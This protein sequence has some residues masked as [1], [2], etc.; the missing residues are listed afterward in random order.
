V[1]RSL[2]RS[3]RFRITAAATLIVTLATV[4]G[5][6]VFITVLRGSLLDGVASAAQTDAT[7]IGDRLEEAGIASV[8]DDEDVDDRFFQVV[9][10]DGALLVSSENAAASAVTTTVTDAA[11]TITL[12]GQ[13]YTV[14][15]VS[16]E[17]EET[18]ADEALED[19]L[20]DSTEDS[21]DDSSDDDSGD[22]SDAGDAGDSGDSGDAEDTDEIVTVVAGR[23]TETAADTIG[24]VTNLLAIAVPLLIVLVAATTWFTVG[25]TL[26]PIERMRRE[27]DDVTSSR[28]DR[29]LADPGTAD[30]VGRLAMTLNSMLD[31]LDTSQRAQRRFVSDASHELKSP[32]A[33]LRQYA[34]VASAHPDRISPAELS[35]AVLD[36]GARLE[37]LVQG[38]LV[39]AK[40]DESSLTAAAAPVDLDDILL[41]EAHRVKSSTPL[42]VDATHVGAAQVS[43]DAGM[44]NQ[45]IRNLVDNAVRH[46]HSAIALFLTETDDTAIIAIEDDGDGVPEAERERIF[47]RFVRLDD[48]RARESGGSGLGLAIVSEL[49]RAHGGQVSVT[50]ASIG[51][52][53]FEVRLPVA[54]A[55]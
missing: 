47:D 49:V 11:S 21:S 46:A 23:S 31:R 50:V 12:D 5:A 53:R 28:L 35:D 32:L 39:L 40:A 24:T 6:A 25:R 33:S 37:R 48:A 13:E 34:E 10:S 18:D 20:E 26:R 41:G 36:E 30:E 51:G 42:T 22:S 43:G 1:A 17:P 7:S 2:P 29:R 16:A 4:A 38:M 54:S 52:A 45:V 19:A 55:R 14:V 3:L 27:V 15:T 44:L 8:D 9:A